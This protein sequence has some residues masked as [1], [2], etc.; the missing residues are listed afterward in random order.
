MTETERKFL[1]LSAAYQ[2]EAFRKTRISQGYLNSDKNRSVR[3]RI[4]DEKAYLTIKGPSGNSGASRYEWEEEIDKKDAEALMELC[5]PGRIEKNRYEVKLGNHIFEVDEFYGD[6]EG[7]VVAEIELK[8]ENDPF[9][10]PS[11]LGKEVTGDVR[12]YNASLSKHPY[13]S[14][15]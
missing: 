12:Y 5:E 1:V 10:K 3:I 6:N 8:D 13:K 11:W 7:L 2:Q 15:K 14:W 4:R 9:Q